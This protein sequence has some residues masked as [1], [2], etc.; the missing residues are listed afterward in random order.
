VTGQ[1]FARLGGGTIY[2]SPPVMDR[3]EFHRQTGPDS[4]EAGGV[5]LG[6]HLLDCMDLIVDDITQ[7]SRMDKRAWAAFFRS[8]THHKLALKRW[9]DRNKKSAYLGSWHTHPESDPRP[10]STDLSDWRK[11]LTHDSYE[12]DNLYFVI[13]GIDHLRIWEGDRTGGIAEIEQDRRK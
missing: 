11:A 9:K 5:L 12:G 13:V 8:F 10:S 3:L 1:L 6:R 2:L 7:P 4:R